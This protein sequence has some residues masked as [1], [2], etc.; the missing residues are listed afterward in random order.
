MAVDELLQS[1]RLSWFGGTG[2]DS[3]VVVSSRVRLARNLV[4]LPYPGRADHRQLAEIQQ[5]LDTAF[6]D[7]GTEFGQDFD[8]LVMDRLT[9]LQRSVL[10]EKY[11]ISEKFAEPQPHRLAYISADTRIS[12]LVNE[13]DHLRIQSMTPGLSLTQAFECASRVDDYI[14]ARLDLAFD[15]TMGYL[16]AYPTNLG[17]GLRAS[18]ILHLPGLVYTRNIENIVN[19]SPQLGLAVHP[20]EGIGEGAHLYKVSN[21]FTLGYSEAEM[22]ENLQTAA[23]EIAAH[24]R[25]ARKALSYFGKDGVEDGVWRAFGILS[26]ARSLTEQELFSL[27]SRVRYGIDRGIIKEVAPECCAEIIVAGR[28]NYLKYAAENENLTTGE[29]SAIRAS[30]VRAILQKYSIRG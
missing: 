9:A 2:A 15:E 4:G 13:D 6:G 3:D 30:R 19:T 25:R 8:C 26:Y 11:L 22:I 29:I 1:G 18:V 7:I 5:T 14:E 28:D 12:I 23:G 27:V 24:E 16:T 10:I 21:Q 17:T 20:L